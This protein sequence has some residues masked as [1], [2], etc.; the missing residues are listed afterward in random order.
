MKNLHEAINDKKD[1]TVKNINEV[2]ESVQEQVD[3]IPDQMNNSIEELSE[4]SDQVAERMQ[5]NYE[6][7]WLARNKGWVFLGTIFAAVG[8]ALAFLFTRD[9]DASLQAS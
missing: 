3:K 6:G 9:R 7:S 5:E 8:T 2:S 4:K 1:T